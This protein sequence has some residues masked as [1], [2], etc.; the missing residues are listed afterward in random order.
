MT[1]TRGASSKKS[2]NK[3]QASRIDVIVVGAG[4][5]G[6]YMIHRLRELGL[7]IRAFEAG[8]DIGGTWYWNRYPGARCDVPSIEYSF[9]FDKELEQEWNW[10]EVMASQEEILAYAN[11]VAERYDIRRD[12]TFDTRVIR[13]EFD[14]SSERWLVETDGG[15]HLQAHY[16]VMATGCLST[17]NKPAIEGDNSFQGEVYHTGTWPKEGVDFGG[18]KVGVIGTGSSGVQAIPVIAET[19]THLFVFQRTPVYT[20]P[21]FN[22]PLSEKYRK[23]VK[24]SYA[25]I[26][27]MQRESPVGIS[28]FGARAIAQT[29][30]PKKILDLTA[31]ERQAELARTGFSGLRTY[32]DVLTDLAANEVACDLYREKI[33]KIIDD[34]ETAEG[35]KPRGYPIGCKRQVFDSN[36]YAAFNQENVTL[37]DLRKGG[38]KRITAAGIETE[39]E[40]FGIDIIVYATGFDAMTGALERIDIRGRGGQ[41]LVDKWVDGPR[42]YLGLQMAGFPNLFTITGPGSPSVLSNMLVAIEQHVDWIRDCLEHLH[43]NQVGTIEPALDAENEWVEHV[44]DVGKGTMFTAPTC[45]SWYLG[46]NIRGK[47]RIFMPYVGGIHRYRAKCEAVVANDYEGFRLD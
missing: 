37:I 32:T 45:N 34:P 35:L 47:P 43:N 11:H 38:I 7:T 8:S 40:S 24:A 18:K 42:A 31:E 17:P 19:A 25:D 30:V 2:S 10:S 23:E 3:D 27:K 12:I 6:M 4:F 41:R 36:Y 9:S 21:A 44:N 20:L 5:A 1:S 22:R 39:Q 33:E 14:D 28:S 26:R 15:E 16:C 13:M 46:A 29:P